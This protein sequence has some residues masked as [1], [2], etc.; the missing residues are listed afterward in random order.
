[1]DKKTGEKM[2]KT[3]A[4]SVL[5]AIC[6]LLF[7]LSSPAAVRPI[8]TAWDI[9]NGN[10]RL[11]DINF[12]QAESVR[13]TLQ[14]TDGANAYR[15]TNSNLIVVWEITGWNDYTNVYSIATGTVISATNGI[16]SYS[17][18]PAQANLSPGTY[19]GYVRALQ[20]VSNQLDQVAVLAW[21]RIK[22]E[23]SPDSRNYNI[24]GPLTYPPIY[25]EAD[26]EAI[27]NQIGSLQSE[28][29]SLSNRV[30]AAESA[31]TNL[32]SQMSTVTGWGDHA[33]LYPLMAAWNATN[34]ALWNAMGNRLETS[35]FTGWTN[36][37]HSINTNL[38]AIVTLA[39]NDIS[40]LKSG[41]GVWNSVTGKV[42]RTDA[43]YTGTVATAAAAFGWGDHALAGYLTSA[44]PQTVTSVNGLT[45]AVVITAAS[46]GAA[47]GTL[48][49]VSN[50]TATNLTVVDTLEVKAQAVSVSGLL[51]GYQLPAEFAG[52][53]TYWGKE[54]IYMSGMQLFTNSF[55]N[56]MFIEN[57]YFCGQ[58]GSWTIGPSQGGVPYGS[59][60]NC[61]SLIDGV[62]Y[63]FDANEGPIATTD[64]QTVRLPFYSA[65]NGNVRAENLVSGK[66]FL[67]NAD[68][69]VIENKPGGIG[70]VGDAP[71]VNMID[72]VGMPTAVMFRWVGQGYDTFEIAQREMSID[73]FG[74]V[75][76]GAG[77]Y[78]FI[79]LSTSKAE[80]FYP[81][82][83]HKYPTNRESA[84]T[85][86]LYT[87]G[88]NELL[89]IKK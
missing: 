15:L 55:G 67:L 5:S 20:T 53:Y 73:E 27:T 63:Q 79:Y 47:T 62:W 3:S 77:Y 49:S 88:T 29:V 19:R 44:P 6:I 82:T 11:V 50:G 35:V 39:T 10:K 42:D 64:I 61:Y 57:G 45:G 33:G 59:S 51:S 8:S 48:L 40:G 14:T 54:Q 74:V 25:T 38:A 46:I 23:Y 52:E 18:T 66:G 9:Q 81:V 72:T 32:Q 24:V 37:Q 21:Q 16:S 41:T 36:A 76:Y 71:A 65:S 4:R 75:T 34:S 1:M 83:L 89:Y 28:V 56:F 17:L 31:I 30:D 78:P 80:I 2:K 84:T 60:T 70:M 85:G 26:L 68:Y 12:F 86:Q 43:T 58:Y 13:L 7:A 69:S 22:V 87:I